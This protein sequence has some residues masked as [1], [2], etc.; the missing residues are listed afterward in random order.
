MPLDNES[1]EY[2]RQKVSSLEGKKIR[3]VSKH[4][5][6]Y[7]VIKFTDGTGLTVDLDNLFDK[8]GMRFEDDS[9]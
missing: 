9:R 4:D 3:A 2:T 7:L 1:D 5:R 6:G 8:N